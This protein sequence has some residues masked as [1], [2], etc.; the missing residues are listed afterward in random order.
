M[1][2]RAGGINDMEQAARLYQKQGNNQYYQ[3]AIDVLKIWQ[4]TSGN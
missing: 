1:N 2:D 3:Y 4:Q